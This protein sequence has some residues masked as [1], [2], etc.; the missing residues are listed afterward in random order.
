[1]RFLSIKK[2]RRVHQIINCTEMV[3]ALTEALIAAAIVATVSVEAQPQPGFAQL[4]GTNAVSVIMIACCT[5]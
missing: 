1:M 2:Q 4:F 5:R 3:L